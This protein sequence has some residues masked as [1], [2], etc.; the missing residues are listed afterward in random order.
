MISPV[1]GEH[2]AQGLVTTDV[3]LT[4]K[5][6]CWLKDFGHPSDLWQLLPALARSQPVSSHSPGLLPLPCPP[7]LDVQGQSVLRKSHLTKAQ[8]MTLSRSRV[9][10]GV[11][12][13]KSMY[14]P[15]R[16]VMSDSLQSHGL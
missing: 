7:F 10:A 5:A 6:A 9:F 16:S 12:D 15:S 11:I 13:L 2:G 14:M 3:A 1:V 8:S 4:Q